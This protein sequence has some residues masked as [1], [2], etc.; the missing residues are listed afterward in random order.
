MK[1]FPATPSSLPAVA[2]AF[3][4]L[5]G[6]A[7]NANA[8]RGTGPA[9]GKPSP[10][11]LKSNEPMPA[12]SVR[13][14]QFKV[15]EMERDAA[16]IRTPEQEKLALARIAE[17]YEK[18][19]VV[20]NKMMSAVMSATTPNFQRIADATSEIKTRAARMRENLRLAEA[21]ASAFAKQ[22]EYKKPEDVAGIKAS[23]L[24]L[25][26]SIMSFVKNP[27]F[28]N[29]GVMDL[30]QAAKASADLQ[31]IIEFSRLLNKDA[32]RLSKAPAKT[33]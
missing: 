26:G 27:I 15:V 9:N 20:N 24:S 7:T 17:D 4:I 19:Q 33:N 11:T 32:Q 31:T 6:L 23:L 29:P 1:R 22:P 25:D 30:E 2:L 12:P 3:L 10:D 5:F 14:R 28:K 21:D 18:L 8:Q 16:R 13:E